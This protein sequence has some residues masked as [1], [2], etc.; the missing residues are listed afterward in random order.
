MK[1]T[2]ILSSL[3]ATASYP[4]ALVAQTIGIISIQLPSFSAVLGAYS[5]VSVLAFAFRD[6]SRHTTTTTHV[7][8]PAGAIE[9]RPAF[10][11][12]TLTNSM[13]HTN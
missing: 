9:A 6:Y 2:F 10:R 13:L 8:A 11:S 4:V 3:I 1:N 5:A 7:S 12:L